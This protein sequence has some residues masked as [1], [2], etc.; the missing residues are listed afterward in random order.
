[1]RRK[2][3]FVPA[4]VLAFAPLPV[5]AF[6]WASVVQ[7]LKETEREMSAWAVNVKQ[8]ALSANLMGNSERVA[9]QQLKNAMDAIEIGEKA[10]RV[11]ID[12][13]PVTGQPSS[14]RCTIQRHNAIHVEAQA[15]RD[16][17]HRKLMTSYAAGR[18][19]SRIEA[20]SNWLKNHHAHYC[21]VSEAKQGM[22]Q[23]TADGMQGWDTNYAGAFMELTLA[24][25]AELAAYDYAASLI[26]ARAEAGIDC[27]SA[28]CVAAQVNHFSFAAAGAMVAHSIVGQAVDRRQPFLSGQ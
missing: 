5:Q 28:D 12:Y 23:L 3:L 14:A 19:S 17:D 22:C 24:P 10:Y 27:E 13:S 11:A 2:F 15:Q 6:S 25:E 4:A 9:K 7:F 20:Q 1:M 8:T 26:D 16:V 21:T 18:V